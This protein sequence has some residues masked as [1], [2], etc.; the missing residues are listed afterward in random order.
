MWKRYT[1]IFILSAAVLLVAAACAK[2]PAVGSSN[3]VAEEAP[4]SETAAGTDNVEAVAPSSD[5]DRVVE[6]ELSEFA[7]DAASFEFAAGETVEFVV[8]NSGV[9]EHEF[10]LSNQDRVDEHVEG[11][12]SDHDEGTMSDDEMDEMDDEDAD[13][14][15][16]E[17]D[18]DEAEAE[19]A[20]LIL[21]AGETGTLTFTFP[22]NDQDYTAAV[23]LIPGHYEAGM[24]TDLSF[25][26]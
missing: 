6:V 22:D 26:V 2:T 12:H 5:A 20:V 24:A 4:T 8:T 17:A 14:D 21:A 7:I 1:K 15:D 25:G 3:N 11:G 23:C 18:H 9:V 19:D 10:R 13:H 16:A